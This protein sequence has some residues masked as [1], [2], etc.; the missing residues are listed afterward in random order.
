MGFGAGFGA[1]FGPAFENQRQRE[2]EKDTD[3]FRYRMEDL[4]K[5][6]DRYYEW[7]KKDAAATSLA[8]QYVQMF[9][10]PPEAVGAA[11]E[12]LLNG[13]DE[14][15]LGKMLA[16]K[17]FVPKANQPAQTGGTT[18]TP[19][20]TDQQMTDA[21]LDSGDASMPMGGG[22]APG[23]EF[24]TAPTSTTQFDQHGLL[25]KVFPGMKG[26]ASRQQRTDQRVQQTTGMSA[27]EIAQLDKGPPIVTTPSANGTWEDLPDTSVQE[28]SIKA[29]QVA[30]DAI[31]DAKA[32]P[33]DA[34]KKTGAEIAQRHL[35]AINAQKVMEADLDAFSGT[36]TP[37]GSTG[38]LDIIKVPNKNYDPKNPASKPYIYSSGQWDGAG[39]FIDSEGKIIPGAQR[40]SP[41]ERKLLTEAYKAAGPKIKEINDSTLAL[42]GLIRTGTEMRKILESTDANV[43]QDWT[44][45]FARFGQGLTAEGAAAADVLSKAEQQTGTEVDAA[46]VEEAVRTL[47]DVNKSYINSEAGKLA[48][49]SLTFQSQA[50]LAS[51][52]YGMA[53]NQN[54]KAL[55]ENERQ[56]LQKLSTGGNTKEQFYQIFAGSVHNLQDQLATASEQVAT[57]P[58]VQDFMFNSQTEPPPGFAPPPVDSYLKDPATKDFMAVLDH[59]NNITPAGAD[60]GATSPATGTTPPPAETPAAPTTDTGQQSN[61]KTVVGKQA[62]E[63]GVMWIILKDDQ[64]QITKQ[65]AQ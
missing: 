37:P 54:G 39:H 48:Q 28:S 24:P 38:G 36:G 7:Q 19:S 13:G 23:A 9:N 18:P 3:S 41:D 10:Q 60:T 22:T 26:P 1:A 49:A 43:L 16:A 51:Y 14:T 5:S 55:Q 65:R 34:T 17:K 40:R 63:Q 11:R 6:K 59:Y 46:Q 61:G 8:K 53:L 20:G 57:I 47:Q 4:I 30:A 45:A 15:T 58:E 50:V 42:T 64:G 25:A 35:D 27:A 32:H 56:M 31:A 33:D 29:A 21:G 12:F 62:D 44:T 2:H 52:Y